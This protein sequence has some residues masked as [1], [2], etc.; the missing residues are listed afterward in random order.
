M[1]LIRFATATITTPHIITTIY[2]AAAGQTAIQHLIH[3]LI[4][5]AA[6]IQIQQQFPLLSSIQ[7]QAPAEVLPL[8]LK[9]I[10][11]ITI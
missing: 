4:K 7:Y 8:R 5:P 11:L 1:L 3:H 9:R 6:S 2:Q 10:H